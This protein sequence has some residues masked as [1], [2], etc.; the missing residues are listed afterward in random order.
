[1]AET[2]FL[3]PGQGSQYVGMGKE[4][5]QRFP[6]CRLWF[7]EA[8]DI[9]GTDLT[10]LC[11]E[12]PEEEL[13]ETR[14]TQP[15]LFVKSWAAWSAVRDALSADFVAGH[16]LGEYSALAVAGA[17]SFEDGVRAVRKRGELMWE[18]GVK[19]PGTMAAVLGLDRA[20]AEALCE[21]AS[22]AGLVQPANLN[23]PGQVVVSGEVAGVE[24]TVE[25]APERGAKKAMV[26]NVSGAFHSALMEDAQSELAGF[27]DGIEIRDAS[28]PVIANV[29]ARPVTDAA[30]IRKN[31]VDQMT[32]PVRWEES[33]RFL[34]DQGIT[35]FREIGAGR[36][37]RGLLRSLDRSARC[38]AIGS[39]ESVAEIL[40]QGGVQ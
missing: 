6:E 7:D 17:I 16:S 28:V 26:L 34:L 33:M 3:F 11:F 5:C 4:L 13:R 23:C 18:S 39:G 14:N 40:A 27:L 37:L 36:V 12:G 2:A 32:S 19:R 1:M 29:S 15:A 30:T 25:L 21:E 20:A 9:I 8:S 31:L 35:E 38:V 10:R 24:R 22:S